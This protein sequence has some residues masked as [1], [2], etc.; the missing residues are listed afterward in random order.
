M[1]DGAI[2]RVIESCNAYL[3]DADHSFMAETFDERL[4]GLAGLTEEEKAAYTA[5]PSTN[6]LSL[7]TKA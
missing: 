3:L 6:A 5:K 2:D 4:E 7:L 1:S